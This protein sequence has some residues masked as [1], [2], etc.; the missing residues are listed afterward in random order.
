MRL[1][2]MPRIGLYAPWRGLMNE[3]W[4]RYVFDS[5]GLPYR[6]VRNEMIRAGQLNDF[7]D[8]LV[9][10]SL[11]GYFLD[12]GREP[13][14]VPP[15]FARGLG[16]EG[17]T[18]IDDF[19]RRGGTLVVLEHAAR[20]AIELLDLPLEDVTRGP[21]AEAFECRGSILRGLPE[22]HPL[23][24][25]LAESVPFFFSNSAAF[26]TLE[27]DEPDERT[28]EVL[29]RYAPTRV[30]LS[31]RIEA[32]ELVAQRAAWLRVRHGEGWVHMFGFRPQYRGWS[33]GTFQLLFRA[34]L[35]G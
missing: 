21:E 15:E 1:T 7:L 35:L 28:I 19:V 20:W 30:L 27:T 11:S 3:G 10:P 13:G 29:L 12:E 33:Q 34:M 24:A 17:G 14:T 16:A 32:P 26:A 22:A 25:G 23:T 18:A 5:F 31:G 2:R 6:Q 8:V 9:V 4:L